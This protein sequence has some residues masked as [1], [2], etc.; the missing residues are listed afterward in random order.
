MKNLLLI[1]LFSTPALATVGGMPAATSQAVKIHTYVCY[2]ANGKAIMHSED[3]KR[4]HMCKMTD[5][6]AVDR[7]NKH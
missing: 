2:D 7:I 1:L 5:N 4:N 3:A 6:E